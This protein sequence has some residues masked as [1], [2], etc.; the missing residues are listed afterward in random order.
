MTIYEQL[1]EAGIAMDNHYSDLLVRATPE[2]RAIVAGYEYKG[3]VSGYWFE[4][5][6]WLEIPFAFDPFWRRR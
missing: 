1:L 3:Q 2:A 6:S 4:G 5:E